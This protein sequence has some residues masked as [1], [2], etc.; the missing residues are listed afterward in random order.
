MTERKTLCL[1]NNE[2]HE[3]R[4]NKK[5]QEEREQKKM[6]TMLVRKKNLTNEQMTIE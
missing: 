6:K 2:Y 5:N 3:L 4:D 1:K